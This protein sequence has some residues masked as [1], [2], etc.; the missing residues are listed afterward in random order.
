MYTDGPYGHHPCPRKGAF[1][2]VAWL[3]VVPDP[4]TCFEGDCSNEQCKAVLADSSYVLIGLTS[5]VTSWWLLW[6]K[7]TKTCIIG[8]AIGC[9]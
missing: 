7:Q 5:F 9:W 2:F 8:D 3:K 6:T 1:F 4:D